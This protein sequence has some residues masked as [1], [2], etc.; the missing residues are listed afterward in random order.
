LEFVAHKTKRYQKTIRFG[1]SKVAL[2]LLDDFFK[3]RLTKS[4][5]AE[6]TINDDLKLIAA[7]A[8]IRK[9]LTT[10]VARH[11][12]A[13][14]FLTLGGDVVVLKEILGHSRIETTMRYVHVVDKRKTQQM[15]NFDN[16]FK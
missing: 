2:R 12:F 13:T 3:L 7:Y 15:G 16:K 5:K 11:T 10:H 8:G 1:L 14:T 9:S 4:I 6:Q